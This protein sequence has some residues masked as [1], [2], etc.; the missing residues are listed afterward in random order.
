MHK[1]TTTWTFLPTHLHKLPHPRIKSTNEHMFHM[2]K[3]TTSFHHSREERQKDTPTSS[4]CEL[5]LHLTMTGNVCINVQN[6]LIC[7]SS[8][9]KQPSICPLIFLCVYPPSQ[10]PV[11]IDI[12]FSFIPLNPVVRIVMQ[13]PYFKSNIMFT[14]AVRNCGHLIVLSVSHEQGNKYCHFIIIVI[15]LLHMSFDPKPK[16]NE[17]KNHHKIIPGNLVFC[18][19]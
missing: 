1:I 2:F 7:V 10:Y 11:D 14:A 16:Y 12:W 6:P 3:K 19:F 4:T 8:P 15:P 17:P 5:I 13:E 18:H 9:A